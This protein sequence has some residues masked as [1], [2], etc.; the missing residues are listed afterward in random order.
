[1]STSH[2][3][4]QETKSDDKAPA[5]GPK[6]PEKE[7][8]E[9]QRDHHK[10]LADNAFRCGGY[11]T[12]IDEYS[13]AIA[14]DPEFIVLWSNRSA[15][16]LKNSEKSK[17]LH[18]ARKCVELDPKFV[19]GHSR[20]ASA[21]HA[22]KRYE[23]ARDAYKQV[24]TAD[25]ENK[26]AK[27][28]MEE[29][30]NELKKIQEQAF[31]YEEAR[32]QQLEQQQE[33]EAKHANVPQPKE[34]DEPKD[35]DE[36]DLL[37]D[38]FEEVEEVVTKKTVE[39]VAATPTNAIKNDRQALGTSEEQTERLLQ[40]NH[41]WRNL[42]PFYVLQLPE[43]ASEDDISR[44]YKALSLL[45]HPDKNRGSERAQLAYDQVQK[46]RNAF[47]DPGR[48]KHT[49]MLIEEGKKQAQAVWK[50]P[51][52]KHG[53]L[54]LKELEEREVMKIFAQVEQKRREVE[55]RERK[56]EQRERQQEDDEL[57][58]EKKTRQFDK[59]WRNENRVESRIG[60]WRD[61]K[62]KKKRKL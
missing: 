59:Q 61:F 44:R 34:E 11:K 57:E 36:D 26:P 12:A 50:Q 56:F 13:K 22:L 15:A 23:Q 54:T 17:A 32:K 31:Q 62:K 6:S 48:T 18:D 20:L 43:D 24:L 21:L 39:P 42:N 46:A 30:S 55:Q 45:L 3:A 35:E 53:G 33:E 2:T 7:D 49:R 37:N 29:C 58:K 19:K 41:E 10:S 5:E 4:D 9:V 27:K 60:N 40:T 25:P 47:N 1:M 38:F 8:W 52:S 28:G 14:L 51:K 16:H